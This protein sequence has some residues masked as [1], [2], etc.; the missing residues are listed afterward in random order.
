MRSSSRTSGKDD[1]DIRAETVPP[2]VLSDVIGA[3]YDC[4]LDPSRWEGALEKVTEAMSGASAILS[5]NDLRS[6]RMVID[7]NVGWG[8]SG[9]EERQKHI[10]EIHARLGEWFARG[11]S[12]D[13]PFVA[14][15]ELAP[16]YLAQSLYFR[17]CLK[18]LG[19]VDL[20]HHFLMYTPLHFSEL[21]IFR[22]QRHG[23]VTDR[24]IEIGMLLLPHLRRAVTISNVLDAR[25]IERARMAEALDALRCG[26]VLTNGEGSILHA[27]RSA[28]RMLQNGGA[29]TGTGGTLSARTPAAAQEL[30]K[31]IRLAARNETLL[32]KTGLAISLSGPAASAPV[33]AH[34]LPMNGSELRTRLQ[35]EAVAAVFI[36]GSTATALDLTADETKDY[37]RR[38]FGLTVAEANVALEILRGDG[39]EAVADRLGISMTT[40]RTHL[41]HI[42]EKTGVR[43]QA[44]LVRLLMGCE[45][46]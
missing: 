19:I 23:P 40:V 45:D 17:N 3:I 4:T 38:R 6:H 36:G 5:L 37:L 22:H 25:S 13:E 18:P 15:R 2:R 14:S 34:V 20:M 16:E 1:P 26:V 32:G 41:T 24:E 43:R 46:G 11:P 42:F 29:V 12:L 44:E 31:A 21:V 33:L 39:R 8:S 35:P 7:K 28:E 27:N 30:R 10:P 9:I